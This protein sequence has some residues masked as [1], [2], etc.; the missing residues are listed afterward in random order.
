MTHDATRDPWIDRLSEYLDGELPE[1][2]RRQLEAHLAGC[3]DCTGVLDELR[4]VVGRARALDDRPPATDLWPGIAAMIGA[5]AARRRLLF[6]VPQLLAAGIALMLLSGGTVWTLLHRQAV[7]PRIATHSPV[8]APGT[9]SV[10]SVGL[11]GVDSATQTYDR[12]VAD[13][14]TVLTQGRGRLDT[15]TV[16]VLEK[17]LKLIDRAI[18]DARSAVQADPASAYLNRYLM[19]TMQRKVE[20]LRNAAVLVSAQS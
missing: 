2:D 11:G 4:W 13:L 9:P 17:N 16:R 14:Q 15:T 12:A 5:P 19:R 18:A 6:S 8:A 7:T 10:I 3:A 20:L 1:G